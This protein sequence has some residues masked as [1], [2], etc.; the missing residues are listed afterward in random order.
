MTDLR[1][2][3]MSHILP[4][5]P[6]D[7]WSEYTLREAGKAAGI[8]PAEA[9]PGGVSDAIAYFLEQNDTQLQTQFPPHA[10]T[11]LRMPERIEAMILA[12]LDHF[13]PNREALRRT[14]SLR[15]LPWNAAANLKSLYQSVDLMWRLAGDSST[16]FSFYT[17]RMTL[18]ALYS[19]TMIYW[20]QDES[21]HYGDTHAFLK[22]RL[23]DIGAFGK[24]KMD[25][26]KRFA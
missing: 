16:D 10:L 17:K 12:R 19:S 26:K 1:D 8:N 25:M 15:L 6:F 7:G 9:F 23:N 18:A 2:S 11:H 20:L 24:W 5:V 14:V 3:L 13:L 21:P 22:R 4:R